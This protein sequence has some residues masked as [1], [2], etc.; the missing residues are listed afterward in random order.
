MEEVKDFGDKFKT[1][2][3]VGVKIGRFV[4]TVVVTLLV[5]LLAIV[6]SGILTG[7]SANVQVAGVQIIFD[8]QITLAYLILSYLVGYFNSLTKRQ[9]YYLFLFAL[10]LSY[11]VNFLQG[12][13]M[14][15]LLA[16]ILKKLKLISQGPA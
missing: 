1:K 9:N 3:G 15:V 8:P 10:L 12:S 6:L 7:M 13:I 5:G 11:T 16:P 14:L 4:L 2:T